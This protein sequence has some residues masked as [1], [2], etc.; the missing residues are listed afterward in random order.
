MQRCVVFA[1]EKETR[2]GKP[3]RQVGNWDWRV[4]EADNMDPPC[5]V[6]PGL[7]Y[8]PPPPGGWF[9]SENEQF[10]KKHSFKANWEI[11]RKIF[12]PNALSFDVEESLRGFCICYITAS[13]TR[14]P[15][16]GNEKQPVRLFALLQLN[17]CKKNPSDLMPV[18]HF[19]SRQK[20]KQG[21]SYKISCDLSFS[22]LVTIK[23]SKLAK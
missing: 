9:M 5:P 20:K 13:I 14:A 17:K 10:A 7:K 21:K 12:H 19:Y 8:K 22:N 6:P 2:N 11:L 15:Y 4:R 23:S 16:R 3:K 18:V 1:I